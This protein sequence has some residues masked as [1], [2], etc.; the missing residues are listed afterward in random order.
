MIEERIIE[1]GLKIPEVPKP[2]AA[3][4][5]AVQSGGFV[6]TAGQVPFSGKELKYRG[7]L[8]SDFSVE[9]GYEAA[10]IAALNCLSAVKGVIGDLDRVEQIVKVNGYVNSAP[11]FISQAQVING[12]SELLLDI[13][14]ERGVHARAALG[15]FE[16]PLGAAVEVEIIAKV[17]Q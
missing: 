2:V 12:A 1:L 7:K 13:F 8:G 10:K 6:F 4:V 14:G 17:A 15:S 11:G 16:L 3:Y 5:P 9:E